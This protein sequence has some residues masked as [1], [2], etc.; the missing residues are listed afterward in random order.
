MTRPPHPKSAGFP[1]WPLLLFIQL[2]LLSFSRAG[3]VTGELTVTN[4]ND[5]GEGSLRAAIH[6]ANDTHAPNRIVFAGDASSGTIHLQSPLPPIDGVVRIEGPGADALTV[7]GDTDN[8]G[9]PDVPILAVFG[10][11]AHVTISGLSLADGAGHVRH[12][13]AEEEDDENEDDEWVAGFREHDKGKYDLGFH[14]GAVTV[15]FKATL[16]LE[17]VAVINCVSARQGRDLGGFPIGAGITSLLANLHVDSCLI[18]NNRLGQSEHPSPVGAGAAIYLAGSPTNEVTIRNSTISGNDA[19]SHSEGNAHSG[20]I[21]VRQ[22]DGSGGDPSSETSETTVL[23]VGTAGD[24]KSSSSTTIAEPVPPFTVVLTNNTVADNTTARGCAGLVVKNHRPRVLLKNNIFARNLVEDDERSCNFRQRGGHPMS[25]AISKGGNIFDDA[26]GNHFLDQPNDLTENGSLELGP[27]ADNGGP[28]GTHAIGANSSAVGNAVEG[29]PQDDQRCFARNEPFDSGAF[30]FGAGSGPVN[31]PPVVE[32]GIADV[33][34]DLGATPLSFSLHPNFADAEDADTDLGYAVTINT[35]NSVVTTSAIASVDGILTLT[36][37]GAGMSEIEVTATDTGGLSASTGF[38]VT[39]GDNQKP[40]ISGIPAD[41]TQPTDPGQNNAAVSWTPPT[42]SDN[43]G[44][45]SFTSTH[46]P[47]DTFQLGTTAVTY[48]ATDAAGNVCEDSFTVTV[49]DTEKPEINGLPGNLSVPTDAGTQGAVVSWTPPTASDNV[50]VVSFTSTHQPGDTFPLGTTTVTYTATDA[51]GNVCEDSFTI[52]VGDDEK[53]VISGIPGDISQDTDPGAATAVVTW[54]P[55][56]ASDNVGVVSFTSS[57]QPGDSFPAGVTTVTYTATDAAGNVCEDSF[58]ITI[59]DKEKPVIEG[60]PADIV[61]QAEFGDD[62]AIVTW[63]EPTAT[64]NVGVT[65]FEPNF[66][67]GSEFPIGETVVAYIAQDAAGNICV[68]TFLVTVEEP[69]GGFFLDFIS[70]RTDPAPGTDGSTFNTYQRAFINENDIVVFG[71]S[72][73]GGDSSGSVGVWFGD[74]DGVEVAAVD[75]KPAAG[76]AAGVDYG[77]FTAINID[78]SDNV[79]FNSQL[80]GD[81]TPTSDL[82]HFASAGGSALTSLAREGSPAPG[83][84]GIFEA[85]RD[86]VAGNGVTAFPA[87]LAIGD[88]ITARN[89]SG[90]WS[91]HSGALD[92]VVREGDD[93]D[94]IPG[95]KFGSIVASMAMNASGEMAFTASLTQAGGAN[96]AV[97]TGL[98]GALEV[99]FRRDGIAPGTGG[100]TFRLFDAAAIG[101]SGDTAV[102]A[103][104]NNSSSLGIS[105][106]NNQ[107]IW[108]NIG[109]TIALVAREGDQVPG[110]PAGISFESFRE[111]LVADDGSVC[112]SGFVQGP[113]VNSSNDGC[114]WSNASGSLEILAREGGIAPDTEGS[115]IKSIM[116]FTC[117]NNGVVGL[118]AD[119]VE[120]IG[121]TNST[122]NQGLW[123]SNPET[124]ELELALRTGDQFDL[125]PGDTR[126]VRIIRLDKSTNIAGAGGGSGR[127]LNDKDRLAVIID[128]NLGSGVFATGRLLP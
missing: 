15:A 35:D 91:T 92:L 23:G 38:K 72:V 48:T 55:P 120:G 14:A 79:S 44:V 122:T 16:R 123:L 81:V 21:Y 124:A 117:N 61:V 68:A 4:L 100:A 33:A 10:P 113:G 53:P 56:T 126:S 80:T 34:V 6:E 115:Q 7:S 45:V 86:S 106:S 73:L 57:H 96:Q 51:A 50:G 77:I 60:I 97:F 121:D 11:F 104:L 32:Q 40:V 25:A 76:Q 17:K 20:A 110:L 88:P 1:C 43:V 118:L 108:T 64:D 69:E 78:D 119:M 12:P 95:A 3:L 107:G 26:S 93:A 24:D 116:S 111:I 125:A 70:I 18:A 31:T 103:S 5:S 62:T 65:S 13:Y 82:A 85:I 71:G 87:R 52:S 22:L 36:F 127:V 2:A 37:V 74:V 47:G 99:A 9:L 28:T 42:A 98:P 84:P 101:G 30:E 54:T 128:Y 94:A 27:L 46:S 109:G 102:F 39:V 66:P 83:T 49:I 41:I 112:F 59:N 67:P 63:E 90:I 29:A 58:T 105:S 114:L 89:D 19:N 75:G 8:D